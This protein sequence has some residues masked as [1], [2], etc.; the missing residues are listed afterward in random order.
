[1]HDD[2]KCLL[3]CISFFFFKIN[4]N[5]KKLTKDYENPTWTDQN[6][7]GTSSPIKRGQ[8]TTCSVSYRSGLFASLR[9]NKSTEYIF[10]LLLCEFCWHVT[11]FLHAFV[12]VSSNKAQNKNYSL[13]VMNDS[14]VF[15]QM[16]WYMDYSSSQKEWFA[17]DINLYVINNRKQ[18]KCLS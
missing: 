1:M 3:T 15:Q 2:F 5:I 7:V 17:S 9:S 18:I 16:E 11:S 8:L 12:N 14:F 6:S 4:T 10:C 13:T